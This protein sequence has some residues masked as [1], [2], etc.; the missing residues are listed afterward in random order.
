MTL[1]RWLA[2]LLLSGCAGAPFGPQAC[3]VRQA[4]DIAVSEERGFVAAPAL[5]EDKPV[6][7]LIDTGAEATMVTPSAVTTLH[8]GEDRQRRTTI[9]GAGG[10][11][12]SQNALLPSLGIGGLDILDQSVAVAPLPVTSG[13][14]MHASGLLGADWL[15]DFDVEFDLARGHVRLYR[16]HGCTGDY[17]PWAGPRVSLA[18]KF[19]GRGLPVLPATL[20]G[21]RLSVL[22]DSG[23]NRSILRD[24]SAAELGLDNAT[25]ARDAVSQS[26]GVDGNLRT[27]RQHLFGELRVAGLRTAG[28]VIDV[29]PLRLAIADLLLGADWLRSVRVWISY[30]NHRITVQPA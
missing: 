21:H 3:T 27:T 8:L 7:L 17:L 28:L 18:V 5:I 23:A 10:V 11:V 13:A 20:D 12:V 26:V 16:V 29:S 25:L 1:H 24:R 15:R 9:R 6:T 30:A 14:A 2:L 4:A 19:Y 22:L